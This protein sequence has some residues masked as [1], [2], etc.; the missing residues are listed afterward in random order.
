MTEEPRIV[1]IWRELAGEK[2]DDVLEDER[3]DPDSASTTPPRPQVIGGTEG[4]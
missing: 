1:R 3:R 4:S 2:L